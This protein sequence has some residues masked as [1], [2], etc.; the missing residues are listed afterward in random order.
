M[1]LVE[2]KVPDIGDFKDVDVIEV[3]IKPGDT[4]EKEQSLLTLET[5]KASMEVPSEAAGTVKE[6]RVKA[7]D[8][9]SQGTVIAT[10]ETSGE[11]KAAKEPEKAAPA[12]RARCRTGGKRRQRAGNQSAGYR[13]L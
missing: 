2:V 8:K 13:R 11:A 7:G 5:D 3:N 4:I 1:S 12:A 10:V 9:V 6:V